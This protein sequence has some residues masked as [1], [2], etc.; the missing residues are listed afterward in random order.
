MLYLE[1][2][3]KEKT[4]SMYFNSPGGTTAAGLALFDCMQ[5]MSYPIATLNLG[6]AASMGAFL[7][8]A[9]TK[10]KRMSLPN[11]RF[12]IQAPSMLDPVRGQASDL[13]IEVAHILKQRERVIE[14]YVKFSGRSYEEVKKDLKRDMYLTA[15]E[16]REWGLIDKVLLPTVAGPSERFVSGLGTSG[17]TASPSGRVS[18]G[19]S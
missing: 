17:I 11:A 10:G 16:A 12:L 19:I 18:T 9:G 14:G 15:P 3:D 1:Q 2:E 13:A 5:A 7:V 8:G 4:V 6:L